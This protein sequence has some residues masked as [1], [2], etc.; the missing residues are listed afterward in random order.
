MLAGTYEA[1]QHHV[2]LLRQ[3]VAADNVSAAADEWAKLTLVALHNG[4]AADAVNAADGGEPVR[5]PFILQAAALRNRRRL[6]DQG[7]HL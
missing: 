5:S 4:H 1:W 2:D 7:Y 3:A 6:A